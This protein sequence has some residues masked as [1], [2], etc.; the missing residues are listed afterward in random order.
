MI[1]GPE[2]CRRHRQRAVALER[3]DRHAGSNPPV[4]RNLDDIVGRA[5]RGARRGRQ[6]HDVVGK[7][8]RLSFSDHV[9]RFAQNLERPR[10]VGQAT[11]EP[12][13]LQSRYQPV[14]ARLALQV[15][16]LLHLLER[17]RDAGFFQLALDEAQELVLLGRQH[18]EALLRVPPTER[19]R[20]N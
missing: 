9:F 3:F 17:R 4:K 14:D 19:T 20:N 13:L 15:E 10:A 11:Q 2:Q 1:A 5:R 8:R 12:A 6:A 16:R 18:E 7:R